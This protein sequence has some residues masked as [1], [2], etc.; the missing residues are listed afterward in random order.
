MNA[1][2]LAALAQISYASYFDLAGGAP[3]TTSLRDGT[4]GDGTVAS[5]GIRREVFRGH[6]YPP[7]PGF[8]FRRR[9]LQ[10]RA[11]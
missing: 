9:R 2:D 5:G 8:R 7:Q 11:R 6:P 10:R 1:N 4:K 3:D